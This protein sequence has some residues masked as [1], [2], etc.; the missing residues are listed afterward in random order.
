MH[1]GKP[2]ADFCFRQIR[3][4]GRHTRRLLEHEDSAVVHLGVKQE[5]PD[6]RF[7]YAFGGAFQRELGVR[8]AAFEHV[9]QRAYVLE[10]HGVLLQRS[11]PASEVENLRVRRKRKFTY[12]ARLIRYAFL[13]LRLQPPFPF[14]ILFRVELAF[15]VLV[16]PFIV[17]MPRKGN[18]L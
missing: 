5:K 6:F 1:H 7:V 10:E 9:V 4:L 18:H 3:R 13:P 15:L 12:K 17:P 2:F 11:V 14:E 16:V 8:P